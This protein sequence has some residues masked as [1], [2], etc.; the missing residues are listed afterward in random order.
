MGV[1]TGKEQRNGKDWL[2]FGDKHRGS[3][4]RP[5]AIP[6]FEMKTR[7]QVG[8]R[9]RRGYPPENGGGKAEQDA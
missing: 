3:S 2:L 4:P 6:F 5:P 9:W 7:V 8:R 1:A